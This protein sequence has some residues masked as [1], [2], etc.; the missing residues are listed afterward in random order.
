MKTTAINTL[1]FESGVT[2]DLRFIS[3]AKNGISKIFFDT[4][5]TAGQVF[6]NTFL[7]SFWAILSSSPD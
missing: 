7:N 2:V 3:F 4:R 6:K 1:S 5:K